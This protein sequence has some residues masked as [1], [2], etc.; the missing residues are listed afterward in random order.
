MAC[1]QLAVRKKT[2]AIREFQCHLDAVEVDTHGIPSFPQTT[3]LQFII[4]RRQTFRLE[5]RPVS[6]LSAND[7]PPNLRFKFACGL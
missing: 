7:I 3:Q 1:G 5:A 2:A 4:P 6:W